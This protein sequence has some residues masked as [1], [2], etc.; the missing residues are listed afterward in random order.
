M[1]STYGKIFKIATFGESHGVAIGVVVEGCPAGIDFDL[2]FIQYE[3]DRRKPGQSRITTQ[4]REA[5]TVQ[6]LSGV[7][8][9]KTTGTPI[10]MVIWNEDQRSKD[11]SHIAD[12]YRPSHADFT[13]QTKYGVRD[14]RGGGRSSARETAARVAA[15]ALA[16]LLLTDLGV[17]VQAYVS[18]VGKLKLNKE[19]RE[20]DLSLTDSNAVRC[21]DPAVAQ[22]MFDYIDD[23]RKQGD[24][25]GGIVSCVVKG[26][27][28]G[29]GEPVFDKL[30]AEL[31][32]AM[33]S[34]NAVKGFEYGSGFA[35]VELQG[36]AHNDAFYTDEQGRVRTRT[37]HSGGIQGG[38]SNGEDIFFNVAFKPVATIMQEQESVNR[39]GDK[40]VVQG[41]GRHDPCVLPRAV[42]IVEA[43]AALVLADFYLRDRTIRHK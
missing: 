24:S 9:G 35:G 32:K 18:Q 28:V 3:L 31:G 10:S 34:I 12:Q 26:V 13:Y 22:E 1:S 16:K 7:F 39:E 4:R 42:P 11:Y 15:G 30:H 36:S 43:M 19:Y 25:I 17:T 41:K 2:E 38:I 40:I 33:L 20:L 27:P 23:I 14:Y 8:E 29:W 5:D 6:V 37:N 21:P